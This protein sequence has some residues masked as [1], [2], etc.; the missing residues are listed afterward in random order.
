[1]VDVRLAYEREAAAEPAPEFAT[2]TPEDLF[3]RYYR[4]RHGA[5]PSDE[6]RGLFRE[7]LSEAEAT[8]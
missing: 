8:P 2:L 3:A 4:G 7:V 6:L 5:E 1:M